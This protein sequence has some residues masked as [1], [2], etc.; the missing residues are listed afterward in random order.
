VDYFSTLG[1]KDRNRNF[2]DGGSNKKYMQELNSLYSEDLNMAGVNS[3][4]KVKLV[5]LIFKSFR[6]YF[7]MP[8]QKWE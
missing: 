7:W 1:S 5:F 8:L 3:R 2:T 6:D 4:P